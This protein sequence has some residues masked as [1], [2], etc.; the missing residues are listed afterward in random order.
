M[1]S[2]PCYPGGRTAPLSRIVFPHVTPR[3]AE[4]FKT[5][6]VVNRPAANVVRE[7]SA[8]SIQ[9]AVPGLTKEQIRIELQDDQLIISG[10]P[11][12][13]E[14]KPKMIRREFDYTGFK[15][16]F[17]LHKNA[18]TDNLT[19]TMEQGLL[20]ITIPDAHPETIQVNIQ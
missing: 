1:K 7:D 10:I 6:P 19:A 14:Q 4:T 18:D 12:S 16:V 8:Y 20:T 5:S 2:Y 15:R 11:A 3:H 9:L 17:R 13:D